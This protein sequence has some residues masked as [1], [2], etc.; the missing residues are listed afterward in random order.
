MTPIKKPLA[1]L[2][3]CLVDGLRLRQHSDTA[4]N[5]LRDCSMVLGKRKNYRCNKSAARAEGGKDSTGVLAC[6]TNAAPKGD[7]ALFD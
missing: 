5:V 7:S 3:L 2:V 1:G 4:R 6:S